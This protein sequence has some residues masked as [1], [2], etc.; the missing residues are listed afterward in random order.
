[1]EESFDVGQRQDVPIGE[2][3][4]SELVN[5]VKKLR[6]IGMEEEAEHVQT[7]LRRVDS[8]ATLLAG[9]WDTD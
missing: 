7:V 9:P 2:R 1:M 6:W 4:S 8:S 5:L 3:T